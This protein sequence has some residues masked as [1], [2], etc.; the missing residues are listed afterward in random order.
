MVLDPL[1]FILLIQNII[2]LTQ[3][4]DMDDKNEIWNDNT[5]TNSFTR[6]TVSINMIVNYVDELVLH[7]ELIGTYLKPAKSSSLGMSFVLMNHFFLF[8][9]HPYI[10]FE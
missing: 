2:A 10:L 4:S 5:V 7:A 6:E 8:D 3:S 9:F 1:F